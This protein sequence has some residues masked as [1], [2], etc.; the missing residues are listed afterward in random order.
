MK[1]NQ[2]LLVFKLRVIILQNKMNANS[3]NLRNYKILIVKITKFISLIQDKT[4][5]LVTNTKIL[6]IIFKMGI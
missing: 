6:R 5:R 1:S 4:N 3:K 2:N